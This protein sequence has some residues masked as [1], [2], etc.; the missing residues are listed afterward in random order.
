MCNLNPFNTDNQEVISWMKENVYL[1]GADNHTATWLYSYLA[2]EA[3]K[4]VAKVLYLLDSNSAYD[5]SRQLH[6][7]MISCS[8]GSTTC[9]LDDFELVYVYDYINCYKFNANGTRTISR[10][11]FAYGLQLEFYIGNSSSPQDALYF[12][13]RGI[14][15]MVFNSSFGNAFIYDQGSDATPGLVTNVQ[16]ILIK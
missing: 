13:N 12:G 5:K 2:T 6:T 11:G 15:F 10:R 14:R 7:S 16:V 9:S 1:V 8:F 4:S 3:F